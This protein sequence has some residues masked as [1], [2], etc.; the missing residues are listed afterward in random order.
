MSETSPESVVPA[1]LLPALLFSTA[2]AFAGHPYSTDDAGTVGPGQVE[3][4]VTGLHADRGEPGVRSRREQTLAVHAG[5]SSKLDAGVSFT[6]SSLAATDGS[7]T[8][9]AGAPV[10]DLKWRIRDSDARGPSLGMR[11]DLTRSGAA[12]DEPATSEA[13]MTLL[14]SF[15][16][17]RSSLHLNVGGIARHAPDRDTAWSGALGVAFA[18]SRSERFEIGVETTF[19]AGLDGSHEG[20]A[21]TF[22]AVWE[23]GP[24]IALGVGAGPAWGPDRTSGWMVTTGVATTV[25]TGTRRD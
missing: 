15:E 2:A 17:G 22:G 4:E 1:L 21:V 18:T 20:A 5:L 14:T 13:G 25:G 11:F 6:R 3:V 16:R 9:D 19:V 12:G 10:F 23:V 24:G 8:T 7:R